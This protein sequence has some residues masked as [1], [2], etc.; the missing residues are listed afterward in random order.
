MVF[1]TGATVYRDAS[2]DVQDIV[3]GSM[4]FINCTGIY[5]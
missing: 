3:N 1:I 2:G 5:V 4:D